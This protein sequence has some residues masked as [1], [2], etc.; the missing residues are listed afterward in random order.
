MAPRLTALLLT[1]FTLVA[2]LISH[3]FWTFPAEAQSARPIQLF[4]NLAII[5][6]LLLY[7][8][9]IAGAFSRPG[10]LRSRTCPGKV[11]AGRSAHT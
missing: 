5:G 1:G 8:A 10:L 3:S 4:K 6:G 11:S 9:S 2:T 7:F